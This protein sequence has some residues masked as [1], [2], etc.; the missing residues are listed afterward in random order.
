VPIKSWFEDRDDKELS[1]LTN[2][3]TDLTS[4]ADVRTVL[5]VVAN[6]SVASKQQTTSVNYLSK[7]LK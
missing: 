3:L 5:G 1:E 7:I 2:F 4:F 6:D